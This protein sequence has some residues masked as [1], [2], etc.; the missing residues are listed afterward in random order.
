MSIVG[1][2][3]IPTALAV[4]LWAASGLAVLSYTI[5]AYKETANGLETGALALAGAQANPLVAT[6]SILAATEAGA[7]KKTH[8]GKFQH[9]P[10][11]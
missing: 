5:L 2:L 11:H 7:A 3:K 6:A 10:E 9:S 8:R 1:S 4:T